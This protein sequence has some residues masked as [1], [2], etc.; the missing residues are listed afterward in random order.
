MNPELRRAT[1]QAACSELRSD[2]LASFASLAEDEPPNGLA[3]FE[4]RG[5]RIL[6]A[7]TMGMKPL[8]NRVLRGCA[9]AFELLPS[10]AR[11]ALLGL[12][13]VTGCSGA[14]FDVGVGA[15]GPDAGDAPVEVQVDSGGVDSGGVD[16]TGADSS[17]DTGLGVDTGANPDMGLDTSPSL[18]TGA[19][20]CSPPSVD[21]DGDGVG[22]GVCGDCH[23]GNKYVFGGQK[24]HFS[25]P[26]AKP[27]GGG[28]SFDYDCDGKETVAYSKKYACAPE[29]AG[30]SVVYGLLDD[31]IPPCGAAM[32]FVVG[33]TRGDSGTCVP[34]TTLY[35]QACR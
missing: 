14:D 28:T 19:V 13:L 20:S 33:C 22:P 15:T 11:G 32:A 2:P 34:T 6:V 27:G 18:D 7:A 4:V 35:Q 23:D 29:G 24:T 25:V 10:R 16:S 5:T 9:R 21:L 31:T 26:Y 8:G 30:C 17:V 12:F 3:V 1:T